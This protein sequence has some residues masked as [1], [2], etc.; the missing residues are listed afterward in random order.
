MID[1]NLSISDSFYLT[2]S[3]SGSVNTTI[4]LWNQGVGGINSPTSFTESYLWVQNSGL[5]SN[6]S[7]GV[8]TANTTISIVDV[9]NNPI[10]SVAM[11]TGQ[12]LAQYLV[13]ANPLTDING[14]VGSIFVE[15]VAN[16]LTGKLY[17][18][19]ITNLPS[20]SKI[21]FS[22]DPS[23]QTTPSL[24]TYA[25]NYPF[26][27]I[28]ATVPYLYIQ[29]SQTGNVYKIMGVDLISQNQDQILEPIKYGY[30]AVNGDAD[31]N[32][33]VPVVDPY[34]SIRSSIQAI[35]F[36]DFC[37]EYESIFQ[38]RILAGASIR[39]TYNWVRSSLTAMKDFNQALMNE[40]RMKYL[41]EKRLL[42]D[43]RYRE[44]IIKQ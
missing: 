32:W 20:V 4:S 35:D 24:Q 25:T 8:F 44:I 28:K 6:L 23:F 3:N 15:Q 43:N 18:I 10:S 31:L 13:L 14:N 5:V 21:T 19:R 37:L 9:F 33:A 36:D 1:K 42:E 34:Q 26:I 7:F 12:T 11:T 17:N 27:T 2:I 29:Q 38:Y 22:P 16:D 39:M 40:I 41:I 30:R